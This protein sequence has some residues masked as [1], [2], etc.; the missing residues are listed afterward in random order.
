M[1]HFIVTGTFIQLIDEA[2]GEAR[3][4]Q[5][6][7][8]PRQY[9]AILKE[10]LAKNI[11]NAFELAGTITSEVLDVTA[12]RSEVASQILSSKTKG[13]FTLETLAEGERNLFYVDSEGEKVQI[14][15]LFLERVLEAFTNDSSVDA[16]DKFLAKVEQNQYSDIAATDLFEFLAVNN[17]PLTTDGDF[18]AFK[19]V[20]DDLLDFH[21]RTVHHEIG[22]IIALD[23]SQVDY[24]R[25]QTCS[26]GLHFCSRDYLPQYGGFFG[27][28]NDCALLI[29]KISPA[30]VAAFPR[31]YHNAKGRA[32]QYQVLAR[33]PNDGYHHIIEYLLS[34]SV[35]DVAK[36]V[37][38]VKTTTTKVYR[39]LNEDTF[40]AFEAMVEK[41]VVKK[42]DQIVA[43]AG[44]TPTVVSGRWTV[45]A[46]N[47][48]TGRRHCV[49]N[50]AS[51]GSAR[52][53]VA[54]YNKDFAT[55][56]V[57]YVVVDQEA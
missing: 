10:I 13:R 51:R 11:E 15:G 14:S 53:L 23:P 27:D 29:L 18:L 36:D 41:E 40:E 20:R 55:D 25:N 5:N 34:Q 38:D 48:E 49:A 24:N 8:H 9:A 1:K 2:S 30:D 22:S 44:P 16:L 52:E 31:D 6:E 28:K 42:V 37:T 21:S 45:Y 46:V 57:R 50:A 54:T 56:N 4:I 32:V 12:L 26:R 17:H 33:M 43:S 39:Q 47:A 3:M 19:I 35:V 7:Q